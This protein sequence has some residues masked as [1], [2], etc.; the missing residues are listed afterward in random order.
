MKSLV[1]SIFKLVS[2]VKRVLQILFL[3]SFFSNFLNAQTNQT[4]TIGSIE[5]KSGEKVSGSLVVE[6]G[7]DEGT[8]IPITIINGAKP[9]PVLSLFAGI[10]GTE[11]VPIITLQKLLKEID[12]NKLS[13]TVILVHIANIP[14]FSHRNVYLSQ[15]DNKNLNRV[16]PGKKDG[17]ISERI[18]YTLTNEV[19][20][21]SNYFIDLH[22]GEFNEELVDYI[23]F[24]YG[25]PDDDLCKKSR[26]LAQAMG[27]NYLIPDKF[28][29]YDGSP[30]STYTDLIAI[31]SGIPSI[32]LEWGDQGKVDLKE[33]EFAKKG[34]L[35]VIRTVGM[36]EGDIFTNEHPVYLIN[37]N[38]IQSNY[39]GILYTFVNKGQFVTK[40]TYI[41][42]TTDYWG[43]I[44]EEYHSPIN[45][46]IVTVTV[47]PTINKGENV[48]R[49]DEPVEK[50]EE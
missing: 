7:I 45:G 11:Y 22:G 28:K 9:G 34:L 29:A 46:I 14:S 43:N 27:N 18:A 12:P 35:N 24:Y 44:L 48:F 26:M 41:G 8:F 31:Q 19:I 5:A 1:T 25:C 2:R 30:Q 32:T 23:Y 37:E 17:S 21:K 47:A 15:I 49:V 38:F 42:Y 36:L 4:F 6:K 16:F 13:G 10:H 50:F 39:N 40:G 3:L 33:I 20:K